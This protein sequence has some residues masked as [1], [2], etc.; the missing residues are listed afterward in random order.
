MSRI[1]SN[2]L[3][4]AQNEPVASPFGSLGGLFPFVIIGLLFYLMLV[5]PERKKRAELTG[6]LAG[7][8][9]NDRVVTIGGI[10]GVVV[11]APKES[12]D[13]MIRIDDNN[14]TRLR[15]LRSA[16]SRVIAAETEAEEKDS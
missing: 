14:N 11:H 16:I 15:V 12:E 9:K 7:L 3:L 8:K 5:R 13:I 2:F 4:L 6:M 1:L 10:F